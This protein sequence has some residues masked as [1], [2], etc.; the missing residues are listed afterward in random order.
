MGIRNATFLCTALA[1]AFFTSSVRAGTPGPASAL[2]STNKAGAKHVTLTV[3]FRTELQCGRL[4]GSRTLVLVLP[5][6]ERVAATVPV[7]AV[8][9]GGRAAGRVTVAGHTLTVS[10][11]PPR[12]ML[13]DSVR[14]GTAKIVV[15][16]AAGLGNPSAAG[17]YTVKVTHGS[18]SF[19]APFKIH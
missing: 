18:E 16:G 7:G 10:L 5:S 6:R 4:M 19:A 15:A 2:L 13:C 8:L 12:G 11:P 1:L 9:I 14:V 3:S 17:T